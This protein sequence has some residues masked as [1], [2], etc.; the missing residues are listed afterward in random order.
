MR[1]LS[2]LRG[3]MAAGGRAPVAGHLFRLRLGPGMLARLFSGACVGSGTGCCG[4]LPRLLVRDRSRRR[5]IVLS[6]GRRFRR[7][8]PHGDAARSAIKAGPVAATVDHRLVVGVVNDCGID[9]AHR[10]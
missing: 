2:G 9:A 10:G 4:D 1:L 7:T 3:R 5:W 8:G 6:G